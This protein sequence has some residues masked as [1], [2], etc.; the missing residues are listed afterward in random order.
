MNRDRKFG[1]PLPEMPTISICKT[2]KHRELFERIPELLHGS[3]P[4]FTPPFPGSVGK[5]LKDNSLFQRQDGTISAYIASRDGC[6]VGRIAAIH[7]RSANAFLDESA[8][9]FGFF[10]C[11]ENPETA[12]DLFDTARNHLESIGCTCLRGPYN[13]NIHEDCGVLVSGENLPPFIS[14]PWN[15]SYYP[16]LIESAGLTPKRTLFAYHLDL[17]AEVPA[18]VQRIAKRIR[19]RSPDVFIRSM[20]MKNLE[21][22]IRLAHKLYNQTLDRN[23]GFYPLSHED[24]LSSAGDLKAF[25]DPDFLTFCEVNGRPV[26]FMFT[27]P[28][29][30]EILIRTRG[31][32]QFLRL[33]WI[34]YLM[35]TQRITTV[36]QAI[37][38]LHPDH[39]D[40]GLAALLCND[41]VERTRK[42]AVAAQLSWI[43]SN[44]KEVIALIEAMGGVQSQIYHL[45]EQS[46]P[47]EG[48]RL[49]AKPARLSTGLPPHE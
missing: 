4:C 45:Y 26:G 42:K 43:E 25:A 44:N 49:G 37:L 1:L 39:R 38:G 20:N 6:P 2:S 40:R 10:A 7:N 17:I 48:D 28:N 33:P 35:K 16:G 32:P 27:L 11:E 36:R 9:Y 3:N 22:E 29:F 31:V 13:P 47:A 30:N 15:P 46:I 19:D 24:L 8:G 23:G 18:R 14:M 5:F 12:R 41:M 34:V 21:S